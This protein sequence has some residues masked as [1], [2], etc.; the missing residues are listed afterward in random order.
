MLYQLLGYVLL[1]YSNKYQ[2]HEVGI[3]L[4][5]QGV[6]L[7]WPITELLNRLV[8]GVAPPLK[9]LREHFQQVIETL[10]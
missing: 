6:F 3:Y 1:D 8:G 2:I 10:K 9:E 4:A 7:R 5:R